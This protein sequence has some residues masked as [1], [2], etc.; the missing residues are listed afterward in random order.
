MLQFAWFVGCQRFPGQRLSTGIVSA[1][2][3][4]WM[5]HGQSLSVHWIDWTLGLSDSG[6]RNRSELYWGL[7]HGWCVGFSTWD[8]RIDKTLVV[9]IF[10]GTSIGGH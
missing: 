10:I 3:V 1:G 2:K 6:K 5:C 7:E 8:N 9:K 4:D